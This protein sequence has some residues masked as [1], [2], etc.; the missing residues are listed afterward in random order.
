LRTWGFNTIGNWSDDAVV[1]AHDTIGH[2]MP[3]VYAPWYSGNFARIGWG[4]VMDPFDPHFA[5]SLEKDLRPTLLAHRNDPYLIGYFVDNEI[6]WAVG[7]NSQKD[8]EHYSLIY[9]VL[10]Q[11]AGSPA[12]SA[13]VG[14]LKSKYSSIAALNQ[15]WATAFNSW[16][17]F[18][19]KPYSAPDT[20]VSAAIRSDFSSFLKYYAEQYFRVVA[21]VIHRFDVNHLYLGCRFSSFPIEAVEACAEYCD[22]VSF[23]IYAPDVS[24]SEW[25]FL[26][27]VEKPALIGEFHMGATDRGGFG[28]GLIPVGSQA[29]RAEG[30]RRYVQSVLNNPHFV[31]AH[32]F[33]YVD[34]PLT[35]RLNDGENYAFGLVSVVD[36]PYPEFISAASMIN[37]EAY[38]IRHHANP[39][40][41]AASTQVK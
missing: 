39:A 31:G 21:D 35:G 29:E 13:W 2:R 7:R 36:Q 30:Y 16:D 37:H 28:A 23:N 8:R 10:L 24:T 3:Y 27:R 9:G 11:D 6:S 38:T 26:D 33:A 22:V 40:S 34:E 5:A 14:L 4:S 1:A 20:L 17:E 12:K 41:A 32:W 19:A 18:L 25:S 15:S